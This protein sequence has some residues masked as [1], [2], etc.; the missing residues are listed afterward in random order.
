MNLDRVLALIGVAIGIPGFL[1]L[2]MS[3]QWVHGVLVLLLVCALGAW[4][5]YA[6][7]R[8]KLPVFTVLELAKKLTITTPDGRTAT[9]TRTQKVRINHK[10]ITEWWCRNIS[11]DGA[12]SNINI[13]QHPP[14]V[15]INTGGTIQVCRRFPYPKQRG[16][17]W[18]STLSYDIADSFIKPREE[19]RHLVTFKTKK[20][21]I[22]VELPRGCN[23]ADLRFT[24]GGE[25]A[26][27]L[28]DPEL[29]NNNRTIKVEIKRPRI[30]GQYHVGWEW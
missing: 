22:E 9:L 17:E 5:F 23:R 24:F 27:R 19:L 29:S 7:W 16:E 2:F 15:T 4:W 1:I 10:G 26:E 21:T 30:G 14:D 20:V 12:I 11:A 3:D 25:E 18:E 13:D 6:W 8:D 28:S